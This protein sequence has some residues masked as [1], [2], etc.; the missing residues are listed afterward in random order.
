MPTL[1][2]A[3]FAVEATVVDTFTPREAVEPHPSDSRVESLQ[4]IANR[5]RWI[6]TAIV[7]HQ[8]RVRPNPRGLEG[9]VYDAFSAS[10]VEIMVALWFDSL[11]QDVRFSV[12][13][14]ASPVLHA[15]NYLLGEVDERYLTTLR[16]RGGLQSYP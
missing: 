7:D 12:Q 13:P 3:P 14:H 15:I 1:E 16:A 8:N 6:A 11:R 4:E 10:M 5:V 2:T 9:G